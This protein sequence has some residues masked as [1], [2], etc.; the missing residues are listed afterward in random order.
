MLIKHFVH[1][2]FEE[3]FGQVGILVKSFLAKLS[4]K[5]DGCSKPLAC[6]YGS[7]CINSSCLDHIEWK[8]KA[9]DEVHWQ[10]LCVCVWQRPLGRD[11][12]SWR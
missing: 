6:W 8:T 7:H 2:S 10:N 12:F 9:T 11:F 5:I 3:C 4:W 1:V